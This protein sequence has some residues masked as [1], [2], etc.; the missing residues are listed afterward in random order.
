LTFEDAEALAF[1]KSVD[2]HVKARLAISMERFKELTSNS[3]KRRRP[4]KDNQSE[5]KDNGGGEGSKDKGKDLEDEDE[6]WTDWLEYP[7]GFL[8]FIFGQ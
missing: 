7:G 2:E 5:A 4:R 6:E 3:G 8:H 1:M